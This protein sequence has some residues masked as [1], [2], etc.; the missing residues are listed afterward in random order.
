[1]YL[2]IFANTHF[3]K[4]ILNKAFFL[5]VKGNSKLI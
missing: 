3:I 2:L 5:E 4:Y 1:M